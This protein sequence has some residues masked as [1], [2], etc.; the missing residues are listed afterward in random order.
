MAIKDRKYAMADRRS[1]HIT[2]GFIVTKLTTAIWQLEKAKRT[3]SPY[4]EGLE[5]EVRRFREEHL[6]FVDTYEDIMREDKI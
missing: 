5:K 4:K 3:N 2:M 1:A 6:R